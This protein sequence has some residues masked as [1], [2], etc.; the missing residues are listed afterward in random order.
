MKR[1]DA[2]HDDERRSMAID[3]IAG[4]IAGVCTDTVFHP[5]DTLKARL[6]V[7]RPPFIYNSMTHGARKIIA[8]EGVRRGLYAGFGAVFFGTIPTNA[9]TFATYKSI[10][11]RAES[12]VPEE[13][14]PFVDLTAG[15]IG[16]LFGLITYLPS[17]VVA[18]RMQV[19]GLGP[20]RNYTSAWHAARVIYRT[21]GVS[22]LYTGLL[23]TL[24]RDVP[25]TAIQF[26]LFEQ[27]K[28][29]IVSRTQH[30]ELT[31]LQA[32]GLGLAVGATA[33]VVTNPAD[34]VK[35]RV[36]VQ[37]GGNARQYRG[38]FHCFQRITREEGFPA[39]FRGVGPRV[40]AL[41]PGSA[42]LLTAFEFISRHLQAV[43]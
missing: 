8:E 37:E 17:E 41:A 35:T 11:R 18:K 32:S 13:F 19:A 16:E 15:A 27:G 25:F 43:P 4:G 26:A 1:E 31:G 28:R 34:V 20:A 6:Q 22:G 36:Q 10:Q 39:L 7:Q 42:L 30:A 14:D 24:L 21:E 9:I 3:A 5:I 12:V 40:V 2:P 29:R 38:V 33:A 23:S